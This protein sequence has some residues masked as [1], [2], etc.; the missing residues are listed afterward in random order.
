MLA[1]HGEGL[2]D[3]IEEEHGL[4]LYDEVVRVPWIMKLPGGAVGGPPRQRDPDAA[5]RSAA[6]RWPRSA[7]LPPPPGLRGRDLSPS[8]SIAGGALAPQG[9]Y[10]EAL[11][12]R[13]HFGWS[14]L[15]SLTDDRYRYIKAPREE[16]YDLERD[17]GERTNIAGERHAGGGGAALRRSTRSSPAAISIAPS[18]VSD[19]DRQRL[20]A[21][22]YVGTQSSA[23]IARADARAGSQGQGPAPPHA[24][25]RRSRRSA[26]AAS[27]K[28]AAMLARHPR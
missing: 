19:E 21:L 27:T 3:H 17:P 7:A 9:I 22:G 5:H 13:Y 24:T 11:Y 1:D 2:G 10:A 23:A 6:R 26:T 12:P 25:G 4:F 14:E 20:A 28:A 16:L 18:A 15:L 8:C